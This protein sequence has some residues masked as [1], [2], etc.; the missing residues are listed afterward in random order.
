MAVINPIWGEM[1]GSL[2]GISFSRNKGGQYVRLRVKPTDPS[3]EA[4]M[5]MRVA[6]N[7]VSRLWSQSL[8]EQQREAWRE[9]AANNQVPSRLGGWMNLSGH[10]WFCALNARNLRVGNPI[11]TEPPTVNAPSGVTVSAV[12][13]EL[14]SDIELTFAP[15]P[16]PAGHRLMVWWTG[17]RKPGTN[18]NL[19]QARV[20]SISSAG[21]TS[22]WT[23]DMPIPSNDEQATNLY[24]CVV[25][26]SGLISAYE[27]VEH[28]VPA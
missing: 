5:L 3:S 19:R 12:A 2:G 6:M 26:S 20:M 11:I 13:N 4:Q 1:R 17:W 16:L 10:Q 25:N 27:K 18:P 8:T 14:T 22:P 15:A 23:V 7:N 24:V 21:Q 9:Y 28:L